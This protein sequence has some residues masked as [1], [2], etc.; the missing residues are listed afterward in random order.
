MFLPIKDDQPTIRTPH[1]TIALIAINVLIFLLTWLPGQRAFAQFLGMYGFT[2]D[3]YFTFLGDNTFAPLWYYATPVSSIFLHG[4]WMHLIGNM[5]FLWIYGN[6][7]EDYFGPVRFIIFYLIS[8]FAATGLYTLFNPSSQIPLV[9]ASGAIAGV[10]GAYMV[11]HPRANITVLIWFFIITFVNIP[12][13]IMLA[14][15]FGI[16]AFQSFLGIVG[17]STGGGVAWLAH[18]GG[19]VF[20]YLLLRVLLRIRGRRPPGGMQGQQVYRMQW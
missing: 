15:W 8:G 20:G 7:I 3:F 1:V 14:I 12:A 17:P 9:G 16:Q 5:L 10:M 18:V 19:F 11:L 6:N 4:G 2:P 13:K